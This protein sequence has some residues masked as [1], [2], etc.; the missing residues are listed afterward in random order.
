[1]LA[2]A[3]GPGGPPPR[4]W[5]PALG[6]PWVYASLGG[7]PTAPGQWTTAEM[8]AALPEAGAAAGAPLYAVV[9]NPV[10]HS[11]SPLLWR[12]VLRGAW[13]AGVYGRIEP[14]PDGFRRFL[15][16]HRHPAFRGFSVTAPFKADALACADEAD[17]GAARVGAAN[18][19]QRLDRGWRAWNTDGPAAMDSLA[20]A[21]APGD[22]P[23]LVLGAGGAAA[24]VVCE[25]VRRGHP[26]AVS[27]R[28]PEAAEGLAS[29]FGARAVPLEG[30][31]VSEF[32]L[33][34]QA[35]PVGSSM[36]EGNLLFDNPLGVGNYLLEMI[37]QPATTA[38]SRESALRGAVV[39]GGAEMLL[40]QMLAQFR[41]LTGADADPVPLRAALAASLVEAGP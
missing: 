14:P 18:T 21:G 29:R 32:P 16:A 22:G 4:L 12:R 30:L 35:T 6:A 15:R 23:L 7:A 31:P 37:Y 19:L 5:A 13:L 17:P 3:R 26:V 9:G 39:V 20:A 41:I 40:R 10:D 27:A 34:V 25:A 11:R 28:R 36:R 2:S 33:V 8:A 38:L 1:M 24:A